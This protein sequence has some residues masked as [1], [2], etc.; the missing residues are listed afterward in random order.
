MSHRIVGWWVIESLGEAGY[1][2]NAPWSRATAIPSTGT[3]YRTP[4]KNDFRAIN[5][6]LS[7]T[8]AK[9][10]G[11]RRSSFRDKISPEGGH[12]GSVRDL[13]VPAPLP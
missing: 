6:K 4:N 12:G 10:L 7:S 8:T 3:H 11:D 9:C 1:A 2:E 5:V 13:I